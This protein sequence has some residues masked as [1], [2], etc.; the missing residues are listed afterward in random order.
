MLSCVPIEKCCVVSEIE[1]EIFAVRGNVNVM[2]VVTENVI[3]I[4]SGT[5]SNLCFH[6]NSKATCHHV[7]RNSKL[8]EISISSCVLDQV[9]P[10]VLLSRSLEQD[11]CL[12]EHLP[13]KFPQFHRV[14]HQHRSLIHAGLDPQIM[15]D[16]QFIF[17]VLC[18][19][20]M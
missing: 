13:L 3:G 18:Q 7:S 15:G 11:H 6:A 16:Q 9:D 4:V 1:S 8:N 20:S 10:P 19:V 5:I 14:R 17:Q 12:K 2:C